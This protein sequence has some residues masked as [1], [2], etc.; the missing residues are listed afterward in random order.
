MFFEIIKK[1][2][3]DIILILA[4]III[5]VSTWLII[6]ATKTAGGSVVV[7][8]DG[9]ES[10]RYPLNKDAEITIKN[11]ENYNIL[12]I[13]DSKAE[14]IEASCPDKLCVKQNEIAYNGETLTCLPHRV[15]V[16]VVSDKSSETD[17]IS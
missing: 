4:M 17:F 3:N 14:I 1:Y 2:R 11:G 9:K 7:M 5:S 8:I 6:D 13:K 15:T 12:V 16:K 10:A